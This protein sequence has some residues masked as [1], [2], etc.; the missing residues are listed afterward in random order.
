MI[1]DSDLERLRSAQVPVPEHG[2]LR[3]I[4]EALGLSMAEV[5]RRLGLPRQGILALERREALGAVSLKTLREAAAAFDAELVYAIVPRR[6]LDR[7]L[8]EQMRQD[9]IREEEVPRPVPFRPQPD[10]T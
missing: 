5:G 6:P 2:W 10:A 8:E 4:R 3:T 9:R 1:L 7:M